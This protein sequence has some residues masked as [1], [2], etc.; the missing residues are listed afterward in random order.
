MTDLAQLGGD[1]LKEILDEKRGSRWQIVFGGLLTDTEPSRPLF[2]GKRC[3][4]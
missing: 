1:E 2:P 3:R 4:P